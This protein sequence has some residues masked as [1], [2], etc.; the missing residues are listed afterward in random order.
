MWA[1]QIA[2]E[3]DGTKALHEAILQARANVIWANTTARARHGHF[4]MGVGLEAGLAI[5]A[6]ASDLEALIDR[7]DLASLPGDDDELA[8]AL[9]GLAERLLGIRPFIPDKRNALPA[10]WRTLLKQW[11]SGV[12]VNVIGADNMHIVEDAFT[13]RL[14]WALEAIRMRRISW[15][16]S[17]E[18][19]AGGAAATLETGVPQFMMAMLVRAG[20]PSRRAA[21]AAVR[22]GS[23]N[24]VTPADMRQWLGSNEITAFTDLSDWPTLSSEAKC[25]TP[26]DLISARLVK[27]LRSVAMRSYSHLSEDERDQI[28]ILRAAGQS[29]GAIARALCRAKT[30]ISR[31]LQRNALPTGR[32]SPLHAAGAYQLRRR[33]EALLERET[34][35]RIFVRDRLAEGWTPEQISGWLKSGNEPR[36]RA[37]GCE[38]IYAFIY[39]TAQKAEALW[40]YL[41]RRHKR[42]RPRRAR[43]SRDTIKDRASIHDRP[44]AIESR[45]EAGHWEGDL[46]ICKCTRP[47]LVLHERKSRV[48]L[49]ARL[50]GKTAAETISAMLAVFGRIDPHLRKSITFDNNSAFAQ[51]GL[52]RTMRDMTTWF[53]DA[54]ASWQKGGIE[55][56]NGRLRRWLP[57]HLDIDR[58]SDQDIQE[59]VLTTNLTPRKCL[60]F[61]TPFQALLAEL[62]KDVQIR[63]S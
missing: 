50:T 54:Y 33:R 61:K 59:I 28:G 41:T 4:A 7:A 31:E 9:A 56:A 25:N 37:I 63:F 15:G 34:D 48:T 18:I 46:I 40:R 47:V 19:I 35:L 53:C 27:T 58:T 13:Y 26:A 6:M 39:R 43:P 24:F 17:P 3:V 20:L 60:G 5:D 22:G 42:R 12:D 10:N 51:H 62:G 30:T 8:A 11:V 2:R 44:K 14:V 57:R 52:L 23:A 32:Y 21:I 45:G 38:T 36:L 49:A 16:W 29:M 1:R 55:N